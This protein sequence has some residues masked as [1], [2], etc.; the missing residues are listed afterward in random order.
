MLDFR[1]VSLA[2]SKDKCLKNIN[3]KIASGENIV[4]PNWISA[5]DVFFMAILGIQKNQISGEILFEESKIPH[6]N[7]EALLKFR[8]RIGYAPAHNGLLKN[9]TV[10]ENVLLPLQIQDNFNEKQIFER[11]EDLKGVFLKN[12]D[13]DSLASTLDTEKEKRVTLARAMAA[14][15]KILLLNCPIMGLELNFKDEIGFLIYDAILCRKLLPKDSVVIMS[16]EYSSW[17]KIGNNTDFRIFSLTEY[18]ESWI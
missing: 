18:L 11:F 7:K 15:P 8:R 12:I 14:A 3:I 5:Y 9:L 4:I 13:C 16:T 10:Q 17:R 1:N 6:K 2:C